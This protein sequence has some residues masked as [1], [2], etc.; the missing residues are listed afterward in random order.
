[1]GARVVGEIGTRVPGSVVS[2]CCWRGK[3]AV[4]DLPDFEGTGWLLGLRG[5][6]EAGDNRESGHTGSGE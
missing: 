1:M 4:G 2:G 3:A 6:P 5:Q